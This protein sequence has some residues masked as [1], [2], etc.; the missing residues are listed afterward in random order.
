[1]LFLFV[2]TLNVQI[3][4]A[5]QD[6]RGEYSGTYSMVVSNCMDSSDNVTYNLDLEMNISNQDGNTFSGTAT[7]TYKPG[8]V[9]Y[10]TL[11][12]SIAQSGQISGDTSHTFSGTTGEG[13]FTGQLSGDTLSIENLGRDTYGDTCTYIRYMSATRESGNS[14]LV[15]WVYDLPRF[16]DRESRPAIGT[17]G[18]VY[19]NLA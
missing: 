2:F 12:D 18:T 5:F 10:I 6:I 17:D 8:A 19:P 13:T 1:M 11:S 14:G 7:G 4:F 3:A 9:E 15:K 16:G